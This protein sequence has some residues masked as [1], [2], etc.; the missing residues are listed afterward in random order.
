MRNRAEYESRC[1]SLEKDNRLLKQSLLQF[2]NQSEIFRRS[3]TNSCIY[4]TIMF[5]YKT[6]DII[7]KFRKALPS[8]K[9]KMSCMEELLAEELLEQL[10]WVI[11]LACNKRLLSKVY[12]KSSQTNIYLQEDWYIVKYQEMLISPFLWD[13]W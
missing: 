9:I 13:D 8:F 7:V 1:M 5:K 6:S 4:S 10:N 2:R 3:C 12:V 11:L